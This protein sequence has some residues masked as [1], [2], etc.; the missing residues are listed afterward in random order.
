[1]M[2]KITKN[3]Q[4]NISLPF[5]IKALLKDLPDYKISLID[6]DYVGDAKE[7]DFESFAN[8][9][10]GMFETFPNMK[11]IILSNEMT[12]SRLLRKNV[13]F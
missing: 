10:Y 4:H 7:A 1:M 6:H 8:Q 13:S 5:Q 3:M 12:D 11:L 9:L 2:K